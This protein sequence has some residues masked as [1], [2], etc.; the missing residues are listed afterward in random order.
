MRKLFENTTFDKYNPAE[1]YDHEF[2]ECTFL[3]CDFSNV[4]FDNAELTDCK[5]VSCNLS[6]TKFENTV[7]NQIQFSSC[8]VLGV[9]F[10]K[11]SKFLF[12]VAFENCT[13]NYSLFFKNEL[14]NVLF[15][16]CQLQE[17]S[18][19]EAN[20][21]SARFLDCDLDKTIFD[22]TNLEKADFSTSRNYSINPQINKLKKTK[23]SLP[24]VVGLLHHLDIVITE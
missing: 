12:S 10:S 1:G 9:D 16:K 14:K 3:N 18:F 11:C 7:L 23:F 22:R 19:M 8:K 4:L 17:V 21:T 6:M 13:L 20:L 24:D 15:K 2:S 5:F